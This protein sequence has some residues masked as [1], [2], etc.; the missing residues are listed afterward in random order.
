MPSRA[1]NLF[2]SSL[3]S[4]SR[5]RLMVRATPV[6]LPLRTPLYEPEQIPAFAYFITSGVAS[7]V[8]SMPDGATAEVGLIGHEGIV[9]SFHLLGPAPVPTECFIQLEWTDIRIPFVEMKKA[10]RSSEEIKERVLEFVQVQALSLGQLAGCQRH[11]GTAERLARWL[12]M[13]QDRTQ[14]AQLNFTQEFLA[15][16]LGVQRTRV[17]AVAASLQRSGLLIGFLWKPTAG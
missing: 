12:L 6:S 17:T 4:A 3:T 13:A 14:S 5:E 8:T 2:L 11:H 7:V 16:M 9:G 10:F 15:A 1:S